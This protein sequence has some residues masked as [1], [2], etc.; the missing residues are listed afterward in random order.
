MADQADVGPPPIACTTLPLPACIER[1]A[2][3]CAAD[4][5]V[6]PRGHPTNE[7]LALAVQALTTQ[8]TALTGQTTALNGQMAVVNGK[9]TSLD[10][11]VTALD[12][13]VTALDGKVTALTGQVTALNGR[14]NGL[15]ADMQVVNRRLSAAEARHQNRSAMNPADALSPVPQGAAPVPA[16]FPGTRQ[17]LVDMTASSINV[18]L[19]YYELSE[20]GHTDEKRS[21][22]SLHLGLRL[23]PSEVV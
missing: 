2:E 9:V 6:L 14:V 18:L 15:E 5:A 17:D 1:D 16:V 8:I 22:L 11:K 7:Q 3:N 13:K 12:G 23:R 19:A 10:S 20:A 4:A 21:R